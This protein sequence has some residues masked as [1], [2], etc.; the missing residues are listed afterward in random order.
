MGAKDSGDEMKWHQ[1]KDRLAN[2]VATAYVE[3]AYADCDHAGVDEH[4]GCAICL[5]DAADKL[6]RRQ[7]RVLL[8]AALAVVAVCG[9]IALAIAQK[10]ELRGLMISDIGREIDVEQEWSLT[11]KDGTRGTFTGSAI[12]IEGCETQPTHRVVP[13]R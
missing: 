10:Q 2:L 11:C 5:Q 8:R 4:V 7:D 9:A 12:R 13:V 3:R 6:Q 1:L